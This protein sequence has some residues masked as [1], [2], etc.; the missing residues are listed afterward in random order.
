MPV[1]AVD[2]VLSG[3]IVLVFRGVVEVVEAA[4]LAVVVAPVLVVFVPG[5]DCAVEVVGVEGD[6]ACSYIEV[7]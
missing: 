3:D 4:E 1:G 5:V 7:I 6:T 2:K